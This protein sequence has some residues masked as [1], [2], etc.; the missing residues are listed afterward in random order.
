MS[1]VLQCLH[2]AVTFSARRAS[3][4]V[5]VSAPHTGQWY[6][7]CLIVS[8]FTSLLR[9]LLVFDNSIVNPEEGSFNVNQR[10]GVL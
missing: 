10:G 2:R 5:L 6:V 3:R 8:M 7:S 4:V 9:V 1:K